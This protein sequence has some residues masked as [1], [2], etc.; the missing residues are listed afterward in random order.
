MTLHNVRDPD[1]F[2]HI[3]RVY[4][5][6]SNSAILWQRSHSK[7]ANFSDADAAKVRPICKACAYREQR[8]TGTDSNRVHRPLSIVPGQ[9][10]SI[11]AFSCTHHSIRGFK[12]RDLMRDNASQMIYCNFTKSRAAED[13]V[14]SF[15]LLWNL[16]PTWRVFDHTN[17]DPLNLRN[18][19]MDQE[20]RYRSD[21]MLRFIADHGYKIELTPPRDKYV[22]GIAERMVGIVTA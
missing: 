12:Y 14:K 8:Q 11:N 15:T 13:M 18:I 2:G 7:N 1:N 10:F 5:R 17:P 4:G 16:N 9:S 22:G 3:H 21:T 19:R 20:T 6:M